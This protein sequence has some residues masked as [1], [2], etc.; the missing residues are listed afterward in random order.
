MTRTTLQRV[1]PVVASVAI[2][3]WLLEGIDFGA[4]ADALSR[5]VAGLMT[6]T[7]LAYAPSRL[8]SAR[9]PSMRP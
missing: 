6:V 2:L 3:V 9:F 5:R 8:R 4:L 7:M 1:L